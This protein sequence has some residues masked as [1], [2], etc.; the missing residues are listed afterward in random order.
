MRNNPGSWKRD[1]PTIN[2]GEHKIRTGWVKK[3]PKGVARG[4][5]RTEARANYKS[6][7]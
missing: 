5:T 1:F 3:G 2:D 7:A 4:A 6:L